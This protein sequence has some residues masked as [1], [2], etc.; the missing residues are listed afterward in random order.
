MT[1]IQSNFSQNL[2]EFSQLTKRL[3]ILYA[4]NNKGNFN[5]LKQKT[6]LKRKV[7]IAKHPKR[8]PAAE[9]GRWEALLKM[10]FELHL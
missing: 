6:A 7:S 5:F 4:F 10:V 2:V 3:S 1:K 8:V 9:K